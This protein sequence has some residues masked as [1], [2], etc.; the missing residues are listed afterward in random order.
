[1]IS[2]DMYTAQVAPHDE[3]VLKEMGGGGLHSCGKVDFNLPEIFR[4]P[5]VRCFDFGQSYLNDL[6]PVYSLAREKKIPLIRIRAER[7]E[8]ITGEIN[9]RF[10]TG[11]SL[12]YEAV[13]FDDAVFVA[14]K[15]CHP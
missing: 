7:D 1:M 13:S 10:P 15:Y 2:P 9:R 6:E 11:V 12:V 4:L 14:H 3:Y 5:S 8:L